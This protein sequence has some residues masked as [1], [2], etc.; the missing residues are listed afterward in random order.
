MSEQRV[1]Y[2]DLGPGI[3]IA[4]TGLG[5]GDVVTAAVAGARY[6][7]VILWAALVGALVKWSL[8]DGLARW[9]LATG[10]TLL[11]GWRRHMPAVVSHYFLAYLVLWSFLVAGALIASCGLAGHALVPALPV[12][13]WGVLHTSV[14]WALV[15][16]GRYG[17]L[18]RIMKLFVGIMFA[19]VLFCA[20]Q[21]APAWTTLLKGILVPAIPAGSATWLLGVIGGV[22]GTVTVLSYGY[23]IRERGWQGPDALPRVHADLIVAYVLTGAFGVAIMIVAGGVDVAEVSGSR[24]ALAVA[25]ALGEVLGPIG[26]WCFLLGFWAA[27]FS[28]MLGVWHGVPYLF[29]DERA[30]ARGNREVH[31]GSGH[32]RGFLAWMAFPPMVLLFLDRPVWIVKMY[33]VAG[34]FFMPFL[35]VLLLIMN[36][37]T[38]WVGDLRNGLGRNLCLAAALTIFGVLLVIQFL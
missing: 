13:L 2:R 28:S 14:A 10:T 32:Y 4:A 27:V 6:G 17:Q 8:N 21:T 9:Q 24:M 22:G 20:V 11:E 5:A 25:E 3:V 29:A 16:Y 30:L 38:A 15:R 1:S 12:W 19:V 26:T 34:A 33:A 37:R 18:E 31:T 35:A 23:W 7:S 36:N